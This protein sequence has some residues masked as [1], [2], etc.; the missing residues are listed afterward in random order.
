MS[1]T[2]CQ[3]APPRTG[4]RSIAQPA[5]RMQPPG[6]EACAPWGFRQWRTP[7][8]RRRPAGM[9]VL[10]GASPFP[11]RRDA[12]VPREG[13]PRY[14]PRTT[15]RGVKSAQSPLEPTPN[16]GTT[17]SRRG[18]EYFAF[19]SILPISTAYEQRTSLEPEACARWGCSSSAPRRRASWERLCPARILISGAP[20]LCGR[21]TSVPSV[22]CK[23]RRGVKSDNPL[24]EPT[25]NRGTTLS[26]WGKK[27]LEPRS[28]P[29]ISIGYE[30]RTC[31][32][33]RHV[34]GG[35]FALAGRAPRACRGRW[36]WRDGARSTSKRPT[37][38]RIGPSWKGKMRRCGRRARAGPPAFAGAGSGPRDRIGRDLGAEPAG[39]P[40]SAQSLPPRK[41]GN[42]AVQRAHP[43][44]APGPHLTQR[45]RH[46]HWA[47]FVFLAVVLDV[48]SRRIVGW[49]MAD[50][51]RTE[52]VLDA[53]N[54]AAT[55]RR[56]KAVI[57]HSDQR[58]PASPSRSCR[59][60]VRPPRG[61][62]RTPP[63]ARRAR[64]RRHAGG[65]RIVCGPCPRV[66]RPVA[67]G[68]PSE[69][70]LED[71]QRAIRR[72]DAG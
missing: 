45:E 32:L 44:R 40:V 66:T 12:G 58:W 57:H 28:P 54:M 69:G 49:A 72:L 2:S 20:P 16:L 39:Q 70:D 55:Q 61:R 43:F 3:P 30:H 13:A 65:S 64:R 46:H 35:V 68:Q 36:R 21:D 51:L 34:R 27:Y 53:L 14:D 15:C 11:G 31:L 6:T 48:F 41:R 59:P 63:A 22:P 60:P 67:D 9:F 19:R 4:A 8:V 52:L 26:P 29:S 18:K 24:L 5:T 56:P 42:R 33:S 37:R 17:P 62:P 1:P 7:L 38:P 47:G 23:H 10:T 25:P 71:L 50:H